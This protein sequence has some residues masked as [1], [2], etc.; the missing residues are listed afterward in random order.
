V[1]EYTV[2]ADTH[3]HKYNNIYTHI[4]YVKKK[5]KLLLDAINRD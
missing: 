1:Y 3:S 2:Y 5:K 4:Y